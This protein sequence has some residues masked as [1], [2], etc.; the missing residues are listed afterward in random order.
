[1][2]IAERSKPSR[3]GTPGG[4]ISGAIK[5]ICSRSGANRA[6]AGTGLRLT[7][8]QQVARYPGDNGCEYIQTLVDKPAQWLSKRFQQR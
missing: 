5:L 1:M 8:A 7:H 3:D 4:S 2:S 6:R